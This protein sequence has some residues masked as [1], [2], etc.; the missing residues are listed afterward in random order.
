MVSR[1]RTSSDVTVHLYGVLGPLR[2]NDG[3]TALGT[4]SNSSAADLLLA[5]QSSKLTLRGGHEQPWAKLVQASATII[6]A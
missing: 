5:G 2:T 6:V 3:F 1:H 4:G